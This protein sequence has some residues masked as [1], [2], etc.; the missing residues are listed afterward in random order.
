MQDL[1]LSI[2]HCRLQV[3]ALVLGLS[4]LGFNRLFAVDTS[5]DMLRIYMLLISSEVA[6]SYGLMELVEGLDKPY[7]FSLVFADKENLAFPACLCFDVKK[8]PY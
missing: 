3:I 4:N 5:F 1:L 7:G 2:R 8:E 6:A